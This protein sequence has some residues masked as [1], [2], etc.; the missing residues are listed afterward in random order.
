V[1]RKSKE[2]QARNRDQRGLTDP[3]AEAEQP[4]WERRMEERAIRE[5]WLMDGEAKGKILSRLMRTISRDDVWLT[6]EGEPITNDREVNGAAR[7]LVYADLGQQRIDV[8]RAKLEAAQVIAARAAGE[9]E[10]EGAAMPKRIIIPDVDDRLAR[11][12]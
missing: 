4:L 2:Q 6:E 3:P 12:D 11:E 9:T 5:G 10:T 1:S 7:A 8:Q